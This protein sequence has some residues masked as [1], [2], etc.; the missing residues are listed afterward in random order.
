ML[1]ASQV[2]LLGA[3]ARAAVTYDSLVAIFDPDVVSYWK[4]E[5]DGTDERGTEPATFT[6]IPEPNV[7]TVVDLDTIA[8]GASADG[9]CIAWPGTPGV[10]GEA[11]HHPDHKTAQGTIVVTFQHDSLG[12]KSTLVAADRSVGGTAS[13]PGGLSLEVEL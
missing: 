13:G 1:G 10:H 8:E 11:A 3:A 7:E 2:V 12:Q 5:N 4:F 6:G 9:K